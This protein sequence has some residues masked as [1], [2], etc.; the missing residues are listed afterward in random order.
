MEV[1][2]YK[3]IVEYAV[4][5]ILITGP[6]RRIQWVNPSFTHI[7]GYDNSEVI[8]NSL[9]FLKSGFH[10]K[11]FY[12]QLWEAL[13][14]CGWWQGEIWNRRK[15]GDIFVESA[16]IRAISNPMGEVLHYG[17]IF[18]DVTERKLTENRYLKELQLARQ[19]QM[20]VISP[21]L[22]HNGIKIDSLYKPSESL[23]G[24]M[25]VWYQ[26]DATHYNVLMMD[27]MGHGLAASLISM[28][29]R[30]L[31]QGLMTKLVDPVAVMHEL[32]KHMRGLYYREDNREIPLYFFTAV[33]IL[34]DTE[35]RTIQYVNA[36]HPP[37]LLRDPE[38]NIV[39]MD[40][41]CVPIGV[42]ENPFIEAQTLTY[43]CPTRILIY[44]DGLLEST[45]KS[46][47]GG[48]H[49]IGMLL[50]DNGHLTN[51]DLIKNIMSSCWIEDMNVDDISI[52]SLMLNE[53]EDGKYEQERSL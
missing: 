9:S 5:G 21:P 41:G 49:N 29:I 22:R 47:S 26:I 11:A 38:G 4:E 23:G 43:D 48:I 24:D 45:K 25:F 50:T 3:T 46:L 10:D 12:N 40:K 37:A 34:I 16:T 32:N 14:S 8:G 44:S 19:I 7:T 13:S 51:E 53:V 39:L 20:S 6:D 52:I 15:S 2:L 42:L 17:S 31:L 27:V 30:S 33:Y 28:S 1:S 36:G 18:T 35:E